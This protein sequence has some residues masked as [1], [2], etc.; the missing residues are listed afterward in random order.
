MGGWYE[1]ERCERIEWEVR[2]KRVTYLG[3]VR[4]QPNAQQGINGP[5]PGLQALKEGHRVVVCGVV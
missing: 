3:G 4:V 1:L 2:G 5:H